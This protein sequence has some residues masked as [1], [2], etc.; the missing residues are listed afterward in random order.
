MIFLEWP[1]CP[2]GLGV[3][4]RGKKTPH[5]TPVQASPLSFG[6][7]GA[8]GCIAWADPSNGVAWAMLGTRFFIDWWQDWPAIGTTILAA[9]R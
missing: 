1:K 5:W 8:T 2:W 6:H 9:A 7:V 3:E 4:L